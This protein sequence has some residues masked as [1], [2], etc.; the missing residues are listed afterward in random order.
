MPEN[1]SLMTSPPEKRKNNGQFQKGICPNK[2]G[3][4]KG[5]LSKTTRFLQVMTQG[6]Q[7][8]ALKVLDKVLKQ[9]AKGNLDSQK[10]VLTLIQPFLKREAESDGSPK[11]KRPLI[12]INVGVT[13][14]KKPL[15]PVRVIDGKTGDVVDA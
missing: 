10:M 9:A 1:E 2:K 12:N 15:P 13:D 11:D 14:G 5:S 8:Q 4:G 6:R 7:K 3:R